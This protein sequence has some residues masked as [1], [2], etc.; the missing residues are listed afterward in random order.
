MNMTPRQLPARASW[1]TFALVV[2]CAGATGVSAQ[3]ATP[4]VS[5]TGRSFSITPR[6]STA[7]T[8]TDNATLSSADKRADVFAQVNPGIGLVSNGGR[9]RG[10]VD[11]SLNGFLYAAVPEK[12]QIQHALNALLVA[13]AIENWAYVDLSATVSQ[14]VIS[15]FGQQSF[16][17]SGSTANQTQVAS[18]AVSPYVRGRLFGE[19]AYEARVRFAASHTESSGLSD[20]RT[21]DGLLRLSG[22]TALRA[23]GW[24]GELTRQQDE[25][26]A[27]QPRTIDRFK[28]LTYA[29]SPQLSVSVLGGYESNNYIQDES[30]G[31][32]TYGA[33]LNW[34]PTNR[35]KLT[36]EREHRLFGDTYSV[37][38][39][40]RMRRLVLRYG[41]GRDLSTAANPSSRSVV[42]AYDLYFAQFAS[43]EPDPI[44]RQSLVNAFLAANGISATSTV[45]AGFLN[46]G[47]SLQQRQELSVGLIGL[48]SSLTLFANRTDSRQLDGLLPSGGDLAAFGDVQQTAMS[49]NLSHRLTPIST[50]SLLLS[51]QRTKGE[52]GRQFSTLRQSS[53]GWSSKLG[54]STSISLVAR[55]SVFDSLNEPY[56]ETAVTGMI[57]M[58]F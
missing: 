48:R 54:R 15:A 25:F 49:L 29:V 6:V 20:T 26:P 45:G 51:E 17:V 18:Y 33:G 55:H 44:R 13:E 57:S 56:D 42:S 21:T 37:S 9:V 10:S 36:A 11:Y 8:V 12:N 32:G 4:E 2:L 24:F 43:L 47:I 31:D 7:L 46:S 3:I 5:Q 38:V 39:E 23:L 52:R 58:Q 30:S 40:H 1:S 35:T 16:G 53:L 28:G 27:S 50:L 22:A 14:Q 19:T 34:Q 41:A